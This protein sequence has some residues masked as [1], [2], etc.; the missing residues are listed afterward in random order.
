MEHGELAN[1][2]EWRVGQLA[3][4]TG[5]TVRTLRHYDQ[6]G[7]LHPSGQTGG[8]RRA[9]DRASVARLYRILAL[10]RLQFSLAEI[11]SLLDDPDWDLATMVARHAE[12]TDRGLAAAARLSTHLRVITGEI[13]R[14]GDASPDQLFSIMEEMTMLDTPV[15]GTTTLLVYDNL[16]AAHTYLVD[17]YGLSAGALEL[18]SDGLARHAEVFAG[19]QSIWLHPSGDDYR[20]PRELGGVTS[21]VVV[22]VEDADAHHAV[23]TARSADVIQA[24]V[25][26]PY[27][28]REYGARDLE[29]HLWYFQSPLEA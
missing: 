6:I 25:D 19:D 5:V 15:R 17:V 7:L 2:S 10:R 23:I 11:R 20:S 18:G 13:A 3:E 21:M 28:V 16:S 1:R 22:G 4:L 9:Y 27:G 8:G 12:Q 29:G 24:P 26:Q 14:T